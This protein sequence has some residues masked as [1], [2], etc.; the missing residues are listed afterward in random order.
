LYRIAFVDVSA[1]LTRWITRAFPPGSSERVLSELRDLPPDVI[2]GQDPERVQAALVLR[3]GGDWRKFVLMRDLAAEDW[4]DALVAAGLA[5]E[6]W[7]ERL[8]ANLD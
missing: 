2:G 8:A 5:D 1:R 3:S 7:R 4:R 6:D